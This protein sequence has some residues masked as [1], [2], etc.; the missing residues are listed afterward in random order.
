MN[1]IDGACSSASR[2]ISRTCRHRPCQGTMG[3]KRQWEKE[4]ERVE[5]VGAGEGEGE[6]RLS[7]FHCTTPPPSTLPP[8]NPPSTRSQG[9]APAWARRRGTSG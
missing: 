5:S 8:S 6:G 9:Y 4:G 1:T 2:N 7:G 3:G